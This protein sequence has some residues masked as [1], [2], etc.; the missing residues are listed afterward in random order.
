MFKDPSIRVRTA[1]TWFFGKVC[2]HFSE[3]VTSNPEVTRVF[4]A[5]LIEAIQDR[6]KISEYCCLAIEKLAESL[7]SS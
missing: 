3:I 7:P 1:I 2:E 4:V 6:P 5:T